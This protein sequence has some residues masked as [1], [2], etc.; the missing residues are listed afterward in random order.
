MARSSVGAQALA[1]GAS[2]VISDCVDKL[3]NQVIVPFL[4]DCLE[5]NQIM[6]PLSQL[7]FILSDELQHEY[8]Q[9]GG[10][11]VS[12]LNARVKFSILAGSKM[13]TRRNA[14]QALPQLT[15]FLATPAI[16]EQLAI[17]GK[18]VNVLELIKVWFEMASMKDM[19]DMIV[20]MSQDDLARK[21]QQSQGGAQEQKFLH[22]QQLV[23]QKAQ[24][25]AEQADADNTARA[26]RDLL[27]L[28]FK[29]SVEPQELSG[30]P[31]AT[32]G[33]GSQV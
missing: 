9:S 25:S 26:A 23:A 17:E 6:L 24:L 5:W 33:F 12:V 22:E 14:A 28:G 3:A 2:T 10:D 27:R 31:N 16:V 20:P 19:P 29:A 32:Q 11:I 8:V 15:Q 7:E 18:K 30:L 13:N 1:E 21:Q 4:Y